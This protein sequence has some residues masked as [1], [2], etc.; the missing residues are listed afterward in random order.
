MNQWMNASVVR[1]FS[2]SVFNESRNLWFC[3]SV[4][5]WINESMNQ[6]ISKPM[7]HWISDPVNQWMC[8]LVSRWISESV[9]QWFNEST[10]QG[11]N[12]SAG[13]EARTW[14]GQITYEFKLKKDIFRRLPEVLRGMD[15]SRSQVPIQRVVCFQP[16]EFHAKF[17]HS[18]FDKRSLKFGQ[19]DTPRII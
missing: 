12:E 16:G 9:N 10:N 18:N 7:S 4:H 15:I 3:E 5:E 8:E 14:H 1:W 19:L 17:T 2:D 11:F 13:W 6:R